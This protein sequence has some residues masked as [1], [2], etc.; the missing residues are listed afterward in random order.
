VLENM[1]TLEQP[2]GFFNVTTSIR[3][4]VVRL[5]GGGLWVHAPVAPTDECCRLLDELGRVDHIVLPTTAFEHKVRKRGARGWWGVPLGVLDGALVVWYAP[6][7][8]TRE[9]LPLVLLP[10][11]GWR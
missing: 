11:D 8:D 7:E 3:S 4:T 9:R 2:Q 1:W 5:K 6:S 10:L